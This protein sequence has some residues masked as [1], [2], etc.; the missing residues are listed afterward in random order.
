MA[1]FRQHIT[2]GALVGV[3]SCTLAYTYAYV[4]DLRLLALLLVVTAVASFL[5]D[6]DSD[7]GVPFQILFGSLTVLGTGV[8]L[9]LTLR[10]DPG[11]W[12]T[13]VGVPLAVAATLWF[14]VGGTFKRFTRH[15]G[16]LHSLPAL[17]IASLL[18]CALVRHL[19]GSEYAAL[20]VAGAVALGFASHLVLDEVYAGVN[21]D[22][23]A[24]HPKQ[25]LGSALKLFSH[26]RTTNILTYLLL[27][28]LAYTVG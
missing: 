20:L 26:S 17:A 12:Y 25:S 23:S 27:A 15:R 8:A 5:P 14:A 3:V 9:Y 19:G 4:T 18:A 16:M 10:A 1:L 24:F 22:G 11:Q 2:F 6:L 28:L 21:V 13:L 7:S